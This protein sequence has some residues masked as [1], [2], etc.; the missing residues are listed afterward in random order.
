MRMFH[1]R[2]AMM[3]FMLV[4][5]FQPSAYAATNTN[6]QME[7]VTNSVISQKTA[8]QTNRNQVYDFNSYAEQID[9]GTGSL[10]ISE[11]DMSLK[12]KD[13]LDLSLSR[14]YDSALS[15]PGTR[16]TNYITTEIPA[17][18]N[19]NCPVKSYFE[20]SISYMID[21]ETDMTLYESF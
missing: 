15:E 18:P 20:L 16:K 13:G 3:L 1:I 7:G 17:D 8:N 2:W 9:P 10:T 21:P 4:G 19:Q 11:T 14:I 6:E 12:G 5:S